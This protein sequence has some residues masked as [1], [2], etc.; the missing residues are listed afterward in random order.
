VGSVG[1]EGLEAV[2]RYAEEIGLT[3]DARV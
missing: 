2:R 3:E 1:P